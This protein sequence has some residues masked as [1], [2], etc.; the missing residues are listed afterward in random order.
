M[1]HACDPSA[2]TQEAGGEF[3]ANLDYTFPS[4]SRHSP[5]SPQP[6]SQKQNKTGTGGTGH[7][8]PAG[9]LEDQ[10]FSSQHPHQAV[11]HQL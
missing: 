11:C 2:G 5:T 8:L 7:R 6:S 1:A 10:S 9:L 4:Q 3:E